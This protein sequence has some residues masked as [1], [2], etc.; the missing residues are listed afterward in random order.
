VLGTAL[1]SLSIDDQKG[2]LQAK[3]SLIKHVI[4]HKFSSSVFYS[5]MLPEH[6]NL[7]ISAT[8]CIGLYLVVDPRSLTSFKVMKQFISR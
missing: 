7:L 3:T 1:A 6:P 4:P 2:I 8:P 5:S